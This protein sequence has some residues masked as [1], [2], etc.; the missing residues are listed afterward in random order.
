MSVRKGANS[1]DLKGRFSRARGIRFVASLLLFSSLLVVSPA[2]PFES[3]TDLPIIS[4]V[5]PLVEPVEANATC[6]LG[7]ACVA[8]NTGPGGGIVFYVAP[9]TFASTGSAC[10]PDCK[11]L[12][13]ASVSWGNGIS[14]QGGEVTGTLTGDPEL[15]WCQQES[16]T[17]A[18]G[19]AIGTGLANTNLMNG[20]TSGAGFHARAYRGGGLSDWY[21][22]SQAEV[23]IVEITGHPPKLVAS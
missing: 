16:T 9:T 2:I 19:T 12:E 20:C 21:L 18:T 7:G 10:T 14:V 23:T 11:Y 13:A 22:P 6:A 3:N 15:Y 8:G 17:N 4:Q 1:R 5:L